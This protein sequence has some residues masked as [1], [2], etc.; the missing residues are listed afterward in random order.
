MVSQTR[1]SPVHEESS[2]E[3]LVVDEFR[4]SL[5]VKSEL[6]LCSSDATTAGLDTLGGEGLDSCEAKTS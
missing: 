6:E 1:P 3:G 2:E 4:R 5:P